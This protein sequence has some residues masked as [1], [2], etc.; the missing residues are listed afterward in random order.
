[1][2]RCRTEIFRKGNDRQCCIIALDFIENQS[3][4]ANVKKH[5]K[6]TSTVEN[7]QPF[8]RNMYRLKIIT[9]GKIKKNY[10]LEAIAHYAKMLKP[11]LRIDVHN[12]KD[13]PQAEG[14]ERKRLES[15][16]ILEKIG[17]KDTL[18][19]LHETGKLFTSPDFA[20]F[21]RPLLENPVGECCLVIGGA[22]GLSPELLSRSQVQLSLSPLTMPHEL[23]QVVLYEQ[24]FRATTIMQNRTYHY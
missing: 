13:C 6:A 18:V 12:V 3:L 1:M 21:L 24:L 9:V 4:D 23:A 19:A 5:E 15:L 11:V 16:R 8:R 22:L 20:S 10:Y 14:A 7:P 17:P 2:T